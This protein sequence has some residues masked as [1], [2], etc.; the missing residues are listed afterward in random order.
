MTI[1]S[2]LLPIVLAVISFLI[3]LKYGRDEPVIET[4]E[5]YPPEGLNSLDTAFFYK[6]KV[7]NKDITSL[8]IYLANKD[9]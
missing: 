8:L 5:F 4:I 3:W 1:I 2:L 7:N 9:I 6:G